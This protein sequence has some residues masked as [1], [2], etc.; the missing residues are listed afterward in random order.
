MESLL[1]QSVFTSEKIQRTVSIT[2]GDKHYEH[3]ILTHPSLSSFFWRNIAEGFKEDD[4]RNDIT[5]ALRLADSDVQSWP[6]I[7]LYSTPNFS[8][9]YFPGDRLQ[10][11]HIHPLC[12][13]RLDSELQPQ[14]LTLFC[15]I[16]LVMRDGDNEWSE[17]TEI[18]T[19]AMVRFY[20]K[21]GQLEIL[22]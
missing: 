9:S 16:E 20:L 18:S 4:Q 6:L 7:C 22:E 11:I 17:K 19:A 15:T 12:Y 10:M 13:A 8:P 21:T 14:T 3:L 2:I 1:R 5:I